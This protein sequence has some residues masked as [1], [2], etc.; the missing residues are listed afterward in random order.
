MLH[1]NVKENEK[2]RREERERREHKKGV[3][4]EK[5]WEQK[6]GVTLSIEVSQ[7]EFALTSICCTCQNHNLN[8]VL[9]LISFH[10]V[11]IQSLFITAAK[12]KLFTPENNENCTSVLPL[13]TFKEEKMRKGKKKWKNFYATS[14][15]IALCLL[16]NVLFVFSFD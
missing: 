6:R 12:W 8:A 1:E 11:C 15:L 4:R 13:W 16:I 2:A 7:S 3:K 9:S 14:T 10:S 5:K